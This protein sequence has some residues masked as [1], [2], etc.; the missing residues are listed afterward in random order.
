MTLILGIDP[1]L[2]HT[3]WGIIDSSGSALRFI[4]CGAIHPDKDAPL[5]TRLRTL[6]DELSG[7]IALHRPDEAAIEETFATQN[8]ASTLKLGQARGAL[9]LTL[10]TAGLA[11]HEYAATLVKKSVV[12]V[13]RAE[14]GQVT[15]MVR[16]LLPSATLRTPDEADALAV[17]ICHAGHA[18]M[19]RTLAKATQ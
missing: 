9:I 11:V 6:H 2:V 5:A 13:G 12:G 16:Q 1:G 4:A 15:M 3:G 14:K 10:A 8:G 18:T 7:V 17:A 19:R